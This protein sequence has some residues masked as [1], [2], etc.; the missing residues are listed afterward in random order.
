MILTTRPTDDSSD[1]ITFG[2]P[3][4]AALDLAKSFYTD[5]FGHADVE[6]FPMTTGFF[7]KQ[8]V[9]HTE[10]RDI[11]IRRDSIWATT[12]N[13]AQ[14]RLGLDPSIRDRAVLFALP[15]WCGFGD[16][17]DTPDDSDPGPF[18]WHRFQANLMT[19]N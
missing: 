15:D 7:H 4:E 9:A 16:K 3:G 1:L 12:T 5:S 18:C 13:D 8:Y 11:I 6:S 17:R 14:L 10:R 19:A 2:L